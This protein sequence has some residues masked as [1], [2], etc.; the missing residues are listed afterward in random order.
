MA[1]KHKYGAIVT[2]KVSVRFSGAEELRLLSCTFAFAGDNAKMGL[3][4]A[5]ICGFAEELVAYLAC[6]LADILCAADVNGRI[7]YANTMLEN[8]LHF[9]LGKTLILTRQCILQ[10]WTGFA[11]VI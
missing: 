9:K 8:A 10:I 2:C 11:T 3:L 5:G 6:M 1:I 4:T 7:L